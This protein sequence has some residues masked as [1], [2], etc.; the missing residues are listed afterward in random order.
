MPNANR[1]LSVTKAAGGNPSGHRTVNYTDARGRTR[2]A[3]VVGG[4]GTTLNLRIPQ[5][6]QANRALTGI[7]KRT[8]VNQTNVW[9]V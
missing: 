2:L 6:P 4:S 8:A 9:W 7:T 5:Y 3:K 1:H